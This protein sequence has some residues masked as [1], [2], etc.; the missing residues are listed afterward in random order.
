MITLKSLLDEISSSKRI[1]HI[2]DFDDTLVKTKATIVVITSAGNKKE[3]S[4]EEFATY[5]LKAGERFDFSNFDKIISG[6]TPISK[7]L[8]RLKD[9][10]QKSH[11][12]TTV[13]TARR[14][15]YPIMVHLRKN[16]NIDAYTIAVGSSNPEVK[17][18]Y[19]EK[20]VKKGY[21]QVLFIDDS[22]KN[23]AAVASRLKHYNI[24]LTLIDAKTG[25]Q[26]LG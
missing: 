13:L 12:K 21:N 11:I 8:E 9:S 14:I 23:L 15:A 2:Y 4:S 7:N 18:D 22:E 19:I 6:S 20:E 17:A 16:Y 3:L 5:K 1:L 26:Y 24:D 10:S 25:Q